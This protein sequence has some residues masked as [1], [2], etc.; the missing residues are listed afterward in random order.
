MT[1][2]FFTK[3]IHIVY[4]L[5]SLFFLN[6]FPQQKAAHFKLQFINNTSVILILENFILCGVV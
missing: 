5:F 2:E 4:L 6:N 3:L 1:T